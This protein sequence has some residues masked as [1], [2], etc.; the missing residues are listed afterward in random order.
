MGLR[1]EMTEL[2]LTELVARARRGDAAARESLVRRHLR[3]AYAVALAV[4]RIPADAEDLAQEG[5]MVAFDKLDTCRDP[6]RFGAWLVQIV[7]TRSLNRLENRRLRD[8]TA[9]KLVQRD[10]AQP[11]PAETYGL[12]RELLA[13]LEHI[14]PIQREV[15]LLHDLE[16]W[17]HP[18]IAASLGL[19]EGMSRQHLFHARKKL[20][21]VLTVQDAQTAEA[22]H[23][24]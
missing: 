20:R 8:A 13:A 2:T 9:L 4:T 21:D 3:A 1:P 14:S 10:E 5:F 23:G 15:V 12:R 18:E 17:T 22:S 24:S 11:A 19:S 6:E 7:R 16:S